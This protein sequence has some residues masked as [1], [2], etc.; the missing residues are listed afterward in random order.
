MQSTPALRR[1]M[2]AHMV[3]TTIFLDGAEFSRLSVFSG[4]AEVL[5]CGRAYA[6][7]GHAVRI[8]LFHSGQGLYENGE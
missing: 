4:V 3:F 2:E 5:R 6:A 7:L 8:E 1:P